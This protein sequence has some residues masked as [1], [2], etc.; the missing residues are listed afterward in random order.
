MIREKCSAREIVA[1]LQMVEALRAEGLPVA[2]AIRSAGMVR[3]EYDRWRIEY[4]GL[5]RTLGPLLRAQPKLMKKAR[6]PD[7]IRR[8]K[9]AK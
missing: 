4:D 1:R 9:A 3:T 6:R 7:P 2:E 8:D 5:M